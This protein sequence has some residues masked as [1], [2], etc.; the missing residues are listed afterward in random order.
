[1]SERFYLDNARSAFGR[2]PPA[3]ETTNSFVVD[4]VN[5]CS[6]ASICAVAAT[7][8]QRQSRR[9]YAAFYQRKLRRTEGGC[10]H[11]S[12]YRRQ[13]L[14]MQ[15]AARCEKGGFYPGL[16][17]ILSHLWVYRHALVSAHRRRS[18]CNL[19]KCA[20]SGEKRGV[21]RKI[22]SDTSSRDPNVSSRLSPQSK[23]GTI[24]FTA[25]RHYWRRKVAS[26]SGQ[27]LRGML[28]AKSVRGLWINRNVPSGKRQFARA[29]V[30]EAR[31]N[32]AAIQPARFNWEN[33]SWNCG[34]DPRA[35][36]RSQTFTTPNRNALAAR[37]KH[38]RRLSTRSA[39]NS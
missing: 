25:P 11:S 32:R 35:R 28:E 27:T 15:R 22:S 36:I 21:D 14:A 29:A 13:C 38:F 31:G 30:N 19:S 39:T 9:S 4:D 10:S 34:G 26:R 2:G 23:G 24:S 17:A 20:R 6:F 3:D 16:A 1:M 7:S 37:P 5:L 18:D 12:Q 8:A 33:G